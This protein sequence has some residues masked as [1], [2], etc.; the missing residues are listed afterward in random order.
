M[1]VL[2]SLPVS[3][4]LD[5]ERDIMPIFEGKCYD[6]HSASAEKVKG[7]LRLDDPRHFFQRFK[8]SEVVIPGNWDASYLFVVVTRAPDHKEAMP[9]KNKGESLT[10]EE[11]L[12]VANWIYEGARIDGERGAKGEKGDNPED[13]LKFKDGRLV[14]EAFE[15][16]AE[17]VLREWVN[18]D[19]KKIVAVFKG[20]EAGNAILVLEDGRIFR[21]PLEKLSDGSRAKIRSLLE[22]GPASPE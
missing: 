6:C 17:A 18:R 14:T 12:K 13:L 4:A 3:A 7:G 11:I 9:P 16:R 15:P 10:P 20:V 21:Y 19:G 22:Q 2:L 1:S 8:K 5:Y